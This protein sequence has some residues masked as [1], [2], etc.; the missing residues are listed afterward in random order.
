MSQLRALIAGV[1]KVAHLCWAEV[2]HRG[3]W[4][5][6]GLVGC[7]WVSWQPT[8]GLITSLCLALTVWGDEEPLFE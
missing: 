1:C 4:V 2:Q 7:G 3:S 6:G 8:L 5:V